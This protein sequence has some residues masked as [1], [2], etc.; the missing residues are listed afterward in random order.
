MRRSERPLNCDVA[1]NST[2][3][4]SSELVV[5]PD[6]DDVSRRGVLLP[7]KGATACLEGGPTFDKHV[8]EFPRPMIK[9]GVF[10]AAA[11]GERAL[12]FAAGGYKAGRVC[13]GD[14][15]SAIEKGNAKL[16]IQKEAVKG[17]ADAPADQAV[18]GA[19]L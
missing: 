15:G 17:N 12:K 1:I 3:H 13:I 14:R 18:A 2:A 8:L 6:L 10:A 11:N 16:G 5:Q 19:D 4:P 9:N 7:A